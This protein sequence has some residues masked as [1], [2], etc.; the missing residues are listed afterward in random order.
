MT[1]LAME[2]APLLDAAS[3]RALVLDQKD[4][5]TLKLPQEGRCAKSEDGSG[6]LYVL[7]AL[8]ATSA[9]APVVAGTAK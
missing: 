3:A 7:F 8:P 4:P 1:E 2:C 6:Y 9:P 5:L